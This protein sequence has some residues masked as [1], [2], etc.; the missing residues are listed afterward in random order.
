MLD[1]RGTMISD[2]GLKELSHLPLREMDLT[3]TRISD[4]S[5]H[6]WALFSALESLDLS[7][8]EVAVKT[9][10][11]LTKL[12]RLR[13]LSL[14]SSRIPRTDAFEFKKKVPNCTVWL[15]HTCIE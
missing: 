5:Q 6:Q 8:T 9:L 12:P 10:D 11:E 14:S 3:G 4:A 7:E 13:Y 1:L 2:L 15:D